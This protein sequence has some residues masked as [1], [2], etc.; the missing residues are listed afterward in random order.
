MGGRTVDT[1]LIR[2]IVEEGSMYTGPQVVVICDMCFQPQRNRRLHL[3]DNDIC[4]DCARD[5]REEMSAEAVHDF[6]QR[7]VV[8]SV[9]SVTS[10]STSTSLTPPPLPVQVRRSRD[11]LRSATQNAADTSTNWR[12]RHD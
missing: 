11:W 1:A 5:I 3:G 8:D 10:T 7:S 12:A 9:P 6:P 2:K 4:D